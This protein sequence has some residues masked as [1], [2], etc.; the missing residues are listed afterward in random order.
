MKKMNLL[1]SVLLSVFAW[2]AYAHEGAQGQQQQQQRKGMTLQQLKEICAS[3][4]AD[5]QIRPFTSHFDC[6]EERDF[7]VEVGQQRFPLPNRSSISFK[8][9]IK[10]GKHQSEWVELPA[11]AP[12]QWGTCPVLKKYLKTAR[13][14]VTINSCAELNAIPSEQ[15]YCAEALAPVWDSCEQDEAKQ[16]IMNGEFMTPTAGAC[17]YVATG[18]TL[19][20]G[21]DVVPPKPHCQ[22]QQQQCQQ[23]QQQCQGTAQQCQ[24]QHQQCQ[25]QQQQCH[26]DAP[27]DINEAGAAVEE[28]VF[29]KG[30]FHPKHRAVKIISTPIAGSWLARLGLGQGDIVEKINHDRIRSEKK[31]YTEL[32]KAIADGGKIRIRY[33]PAGCTDGELKE[34]EAQF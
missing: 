17:E 3:F 18:I 33:V 31:F 6:F 4:E 25:Q 26:V 9:M 11:L 21:G 19:D 8:A 24:A 7:W 12:T 10:D 22:Q 30:H 34:L 15:A 1:G 32:A 20:C 16:P 5:E 29:K 23:Q 14:S 28:I 13:F 2:Q 27:C